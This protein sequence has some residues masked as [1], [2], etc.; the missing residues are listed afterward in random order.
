MDCMAVNALR[1]LLLWVFHS[2]TLFLAHLSK[3][4][5]LASGWVSVWV[6]LGGYLCIAS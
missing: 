5:A 1:L 2:A 3:G 6:G 4:P